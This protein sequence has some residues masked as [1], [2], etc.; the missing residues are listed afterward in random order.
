MLGESSLLG[1]RCTSHRLTLWGKDCREEIPLID[2]V[3][4]LLID[5]R[6]QFNKSINRIATLKILCMKLKIK[7]VSIPDHFE[8]RFVAHGVR[9][10]RA[11]CQLL[12]A[13]YR[14]FDN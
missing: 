10:L 6:T 9:S 5:I 13:L 3:L 8:N 2:K 14:Y 7:F 4:K 1:V 12:P 11:F